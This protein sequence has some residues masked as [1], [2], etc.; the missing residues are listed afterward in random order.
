VAEGRA[1]V[2][3]ALTALTIVGAGYLTYLGI[4]TLRTPGHV[5]DGTPVAPMASSPLR[6][7]TRAIG[8]SALTPRG[9]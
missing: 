9:Y 1:N 5:P 3:F 6:Y 7:L 2:P 8:V 4:R